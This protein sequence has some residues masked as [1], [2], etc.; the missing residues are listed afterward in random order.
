LDI[1]PPFEEGQAGRLWEAY[2]RSDVGV[3]VGHSALDAGPVGGWFY[4]ERWRVPRN[5]DVKACARAAAAFLK[6]PVLFPDPTPGDTSQ[7]ADAAQIEVTPQGVERKVWLSE[8]GENGRSK[9]LIET[10]D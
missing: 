1:D 7:Y 9:N 5:L 10:R 3:Q 6:T 2:E 8:F 4:L